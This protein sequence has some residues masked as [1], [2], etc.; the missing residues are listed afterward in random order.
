[1]PNDPIRTKCTFS[2][3]LLRTWILFPSQ[4]CAPIR[5]PGADRVLPAHWTH[6]TWNFNLHVCVFSYNNSKQ[7]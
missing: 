4:E 5:T 2:F 3:L 7:R 1:M 6:G